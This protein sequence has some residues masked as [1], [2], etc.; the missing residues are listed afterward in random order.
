MLFLYAI[1]IAHTRLLPHKQAALTGHFSR[2][3]NECLPYSTENT[4]AT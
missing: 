3:I 1:S 2:V 4:T